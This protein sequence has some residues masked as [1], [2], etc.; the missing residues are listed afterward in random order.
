VS[1]QRPVI[2]ITTYSRS[3]A[4]EFTLPG[5]YVDAVQ[6]AGG[7]PVLLPPNQP[8]PARL[9]EVLDGLVFAGGGD[10]DPE[11][12]GGNHHHTVYLVDE[13]RDGFELALARQALMQEIPTLGICRGM[14]V[15]SVASGADLITHV[16][17]V[18]GTQVAHRLDNPRRPIPHA[19]QVQTESRLAGILGAT[20][21]TVVSWHH[22]AVKTVPDCWQVVAHASDGLVEAL[23][24]RH[25]PWMVAVQ[26][27]PE[28]SPEEVVHQR[29]F[30]SLIR[31]A[32]E[33][34]RG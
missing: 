32:G 34:D 20:E 4:G 2:G 30:K 8:D 10:I 18:Y 28:L 15:L 17:E 14:Q 13:E 26:W 7:S 31:A 5:S 6:Q 24:H 9:L 25:H 23:E 22:Q 12:Y 33:G 11:L 19:V 21:I 1:H 3:E 27:H 16:P 29:L